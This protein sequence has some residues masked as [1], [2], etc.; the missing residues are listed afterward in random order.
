MMGLSTD[1]LE[2]IGGGVG[3][4]SRNSAVQL[5]R[6]TIRRLLWFC[7]ILVTV[8]VSLLLG[9]GLYSKQQAGIARSELKANSL[10]LEAMTRIEVAYNRLAEQIAEVIVLGHAQLPGLGR[11]RR[12]LDSSIG[13]LAETL[14][15]V[16][17]ADGQTVIGTLSGGELRRLGRIAGLL[18]DLDETVEAIRVAV[19]ADRTDLATSLFRDRIENDLDRR[20]KAAIAAMIEAER[21]QVELGETAADE[22]TGRTRDVFFAM[23][24]ASIAL[25]FVAGAIYYRRISGPVEQL[26]HGVQ[27][28]ERGDLDWR[29]GDLGAD[30]LGALAR[31]FDAMAEELQRRD[32]ILDQQVRE[33]TGELALAN[34]QLRQVDE[35]RM[36]F[37]AEI[38]HELRTPLTVLRGEA[39]VTLRNPPTAPDEY[40]ETLARVVE[41]ARAMGRL[42]DDLL[43]LA[44]SDAGHIEIERQPVDICGVVA[45]AVGDVAGLADRVDVEVTL[46]LPEVPPTMVGDA[47]RLQQA[48]TIG[49]DNAVKYSP[50]GGVVDVAVTVLEDAASIAIADQGIGITAAERRRAFDRFYRGRDPRIR[51]ARGE[52]LGLPIAKWIVAA[53]GGTIELHAGPATGTVLTMR[54]PRPGREGDER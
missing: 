54:L 49:L 10:Q 1:R 5:R 15:D 3:R 17:A 52:G 39:E 28:L 38:S 40:R 21:E 23:A 24:A 7:Q 25:S 29:I 31:R 42:V 46:R 6:L 48:V 30:E 45:A 27:A 13:Q 33:R 14:G 36:R 19:A 37:L 47:L 18:D 44:R 4:G 20:I 43:L 2:T 9:V 41:K 51:A 22:L 35:R 32:A 8:A 26:M 16:G 34:R 53:H 12:A 50:E 11:A